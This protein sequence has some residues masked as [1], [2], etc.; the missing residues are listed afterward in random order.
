MIN[1]LNNNESSKDNEGFFCG[2]VSFKQDE[3]PKDRNNEN[4]W[5]Q[6]TREDSARMEDLLHF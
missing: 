5:S 1:Y 2:K 4:N 3:A 6:V